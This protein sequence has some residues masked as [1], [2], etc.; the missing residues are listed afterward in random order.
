MT[1]WI[2]AIELYQRELEEAKAHKDYRDN[3]L[4]WETIPQKMLRER[5]IAKAIEKNGS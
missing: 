1:S 5:A 3:A 2:E 4:T